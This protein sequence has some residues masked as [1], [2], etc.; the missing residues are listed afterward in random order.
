VGASTSHNPMEFHGL[1]QG[2]LFFIIRVQV[3]AIVGVIFGMPEPIFVKL[4]MYIMEP[5]PI[6]TAYL[7]SP[8]HQS[9]CLYVYP[10]IVARQR[11]GKH[12]PQ[13]RIHETME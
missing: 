12:V 9:V 8:S 7:I 6:S 11:L 4:G 3:M 10:S 2:Y 1:L 5:E 13:Q